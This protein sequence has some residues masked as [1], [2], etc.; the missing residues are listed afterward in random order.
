MSYEVR[1]AVVYGI[2]I[3]SGRELNYEELNK[4][5]YWSITEFLEDK[6]IDYVMDSIYDKVY[7]GLIVSD[8]DMDS[9]DKEINYKILETYNFEYRKRIAPQIAKYL[10]GAP[11]IAL[12]HIMYNY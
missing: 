2:V 5:N 4:D 1:S 7:I 3:D 11:Q 9:Y 10:K 6:N 12:R 8:M